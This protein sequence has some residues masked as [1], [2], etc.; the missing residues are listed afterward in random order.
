MMLENRGME[1]RKNKDLWKIKYDSVKK[2]P[3]EIVATLYSVWFHVHWKQKQ[4]NIAFGRDLFWYLECFIPEI[5]L[6]ND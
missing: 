3:D 6:N 1:N 4:S 5:C 2:M